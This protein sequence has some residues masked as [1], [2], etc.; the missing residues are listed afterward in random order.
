MPQYEYRC[1]MCGK[2]FEV[3]QKISEDAL[4]K[5]PVD[6]CE[7]EIK[8]NGDVE[9][10]ISKNVGLVFK[11]SGFY[12]TDYKKKESTSEKSSVKSD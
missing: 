3:T 7:Q 12:L 9:R 2:E 10:I 11:G 5:C 8:G 6:I 4:K 1:K